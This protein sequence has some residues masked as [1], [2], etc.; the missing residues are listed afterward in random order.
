M[1]FDPVDLFDPIDL[2]EIQKA[3]SAPVWSRGRQYWLSDAVQSVHS[4][5]EGGQWSARVQGS[6]HEPYL[7]LLRSIGEDDWES[8]CSCPA[9]SPCKHV[10]ALWMHLHSESESESKSS[11]PVEV[12]DSLRAMGSWLQ[13]MRAPDLPSAPAAPKP[14]PSSAVIYGLSVEVSPRTKRP[15]LTV[16]PHSS[17]RRKNGGWG[18]P[19]SVDLNSAVE[20]R[21]SAKSIT[22]EDELLWIRLS[23]LGPTDWRSRAS[24]SLTTT[25]KGTQLFLDLVETGR[26]FTGTPDEGMLRLGPPRTGTVSWTCLEDGSQS[27]TVRL[28]PEE[29]QQEATPVVPLPLGSPYYLDL[30]TRVVGP[31]KTPLP[32]A[33]VAAIAASPV[34]DP[35]AVMSLDDGSLD[36]LEQLGLPLPRVQ[37]WVEVR[38]TE[39]RPRLRLELDGP[40]GSLGALQAAAFFDYGE[41]ALPADS[42]NQ[43]AT[44]RCVSESAV[45][46]VERDL[47]AEEAAMQHL[48]VAL[49]PAVAVRPERGRP[50]ERVLDGLRPRVDVFGKMLPELRKADWLVEY[51]PL[52][53]ER[54]VEPDAWYVDAQPEGEGEDW[55]SLELGIEVDGKQV[56]ILP[57]VVQAL[58]NGGGKPGQHSSP[59]ALEVILDDGRLVM[60]PSHR[61][62]SVL[63]VL[64][65]LYD[66]KGALDG[67]RLRLPAADVGRTLDFEDFT[68]RGA[69]KLQK[70]A[71]RLRRRTP[72][73]AISPPKTLQAELRPYQ[74]EG[75]AWLGFLRAHGFGGV[76]ADDMGLGKTVQALAHILVE[77]RARRLDRPALVVAP[78]SALHNWRVE[79]ERFAPSLR[80]AVYHGPGRAAVLDK[81]L[82][83]V[84]T[85]FAL[86][87]RDSEL[88]DKPWHMVILDEAQVIKNPTTAVAT[89]ARRLDAR[90]RLCLT[91]TPMENH[92]GDLWSLFAFVSP[93]LLGT[94]KSFDAVYRRPIEGGDAARLAALSARVAPF[95][96]RR[97]KAEVLTDLPPKTEQVLSI[98]MEQGQ[99]DLYE[100]VRL[101]MEKRVRDALVD[102]GLARSHVV[103]LDALLKLRQACC[104]PKLVKVATAKKA[105]AQ[106]AKTSRLLDML[107]ELTGQGRRTLVFSQ[108]TSMLDLLRPLLD[109]RNIRH[110]SITGRTRKRQEV[111]EAF[112]AGGCDVLLISLKAGGTALNLTAADTVIHYDPWWNPAVEAQ[113]TDRAYR[114]G[115]TQPVTVVKMVCEGSVEERVLELQARKASLTRALQEGAERRSQGGLA[116]DAKDV[117]LMLAPMQ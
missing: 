11:D 81:T 24:P 28:V 43:V 9:P 8:H 106:S 37:Q 101:A 53:Q 70:M 33:T 25:P 111:V 34:L 104:H 31:L 52:L 7:V 61:L 94:K 18:K 62:G 117:E 46:E 57:A 97:T 113:A 68:W 27:L 71:E 6:E 76:L 38:D 50:Y 79:A 100:S 88:T 105:K 41:A 102:R 109:D 72:L 99:R 12:R 40:K 47:E 16:R 13:G 103:V 48:V 56:N 36:Q 15:M 22:P 115:Q 44:Q 51:G 89:A 29:A 3:F 91:G 63:D 55:F 4:L 35:R 86:L 78:R 26:A 98:P 116:L 90:Q 87:Q 17:R 80:V 19:Q 64:V 96:L 84:V 30:Q 69:R 59:G 21:S 108:F 10:A 58:R 112:Q 65:E 5:P 83:L 73:P 1:G 75:L 54:L 67:E 32:D 85:T 92:L 60:L 95:M 82:D 107:S 77:K 20:G 74:Q 114:I 14:E 45:Y 42:K 2:Q 110:Q 66:D 39:P 93:G 23:R 49:A